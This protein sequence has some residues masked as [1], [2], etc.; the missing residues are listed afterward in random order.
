[1]KILI[2]TKNSGKI[3]GAMQAFKNYFDDFEIEGVAV[4]SLVGEE[5]LNTEIYMVLK[6]G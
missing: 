5:P 2:G 1:M 4:S 3:E 6:I